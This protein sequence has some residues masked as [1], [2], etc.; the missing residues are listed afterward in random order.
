MGERAGG[1]F[2]RVVS[3]SQNTEKHLRFEPKAVANLCR[4]R[5]YDIA[6]WRRYQDQIEPRI[7]LRRARMYGQRPQYRVYALA[8]L[9][10]DDSIQV[11]E[12]CSTTSYSGAVRVIR[13]LRKLFSFHG[14][15]GSHVVFYARRL[16]ALS[17]GG[18]KNG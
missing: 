13:A 10:G 11:N 8:A 18:N 15:Q 2:G 12:I 14:V 16:A 1:L 7:L 5:V 6:D 4:L 3:V 9:P 17:V